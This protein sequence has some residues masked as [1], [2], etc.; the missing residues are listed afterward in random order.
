MR[1][2]L[3]TASH[4]P[5][6]VGEEIARR[7]ELY[8]DT[9]AVALWVRDLERLMLEHWWHDFSA[10]ASSTSFWI[11]GTPYPPPSNLTQHCP[12]LGSVFYGKRSGTM[13]SVSLN[14]I[15]LTTCPIT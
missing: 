14:F 13:G 11:L 6:H 3:D 10:F 8:S 12:R 9:G 2:T 4:C 5:F 7:T 15:D 1:R